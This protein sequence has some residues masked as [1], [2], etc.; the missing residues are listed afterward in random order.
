MMISYSFSLSLPLS[1]SLFFSKK[2]LR[3]EASAWQ[4][5]RIPKCLEDSIVLSSDSPCVRPQGN[6]S[7][8]LL[9]MGGGRVS[10]PGRR[11]FVTTHLAGVSLVAVPNSRSVQVA[12]PKPR[13]PED[14]LICVF[15][16]LTQHAIL[17][18]PQDGS[19]RVRGLD[20]LEPATLAFAAWTTSYGCAAPAIPQ[21]VFPAP[22]K[23]PNTMDLAF[24]SICA[25]REKLG[26]K[27]GS[28]AQADNFTF[29]QSDPNFSMHPSQTQL[30]VRSADNGSST[31]VLAGAISLVAVVTLVVVAVV[32]RQQRRRAASKD[33]RSRPT[34]ELQTLQLGAMLG[35]GQ[36]ADVAEVILSEWGTSRIR[37]AAA[38][39]CRKACDAMLLDHEIRMLSGVRHPAILAYVGAE[40]SSPPSLFTE[41]APLGDLHAYLISTPQPRMST[42]LS[43]A[44]DVASGVGYIHSIGILHRNIKVKGGGKKKKKTQRRK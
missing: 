25:T 31:A 15:R 16:N 1:L 43:L 13:T 27:E 17:P 32:W 38:K 8:M 7:V 28:E 19:L 10:V 22:L 29:V 40:H 9:M 14:R 26:A 20:L 6:Y 11:D 30:G 24:A 44:T 21:L 4:S 33:L 36:I 37:V 35:R 42:Q 41:L 12:V 34:S 39:R 23:L 5:V 3:S 2:N 18:W